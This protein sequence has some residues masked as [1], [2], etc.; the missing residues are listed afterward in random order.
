MPVRPTSLPLCLFLSVA[1]FL[2]AGDARAQAVPVGLGS[3]SLTRPAGEVGPQSASNVPIVPKVAAAFAQPVQTN[4][5]WSSLIYPFF[6]D[7]YSNILYAH[8]VNARA[9]AQGMQIGATN[10]VQFVAND[11]LYPFRSDLTVGA[12]RLAA[13]RAV[14]DRYGD[15]TV[16]ARWDGGP[17]GFRATLGHGLPFV[18]FRITGGDALVTPAQG[19]TVWSNVGGVLG[20]TIAGNHYGVFAPTGATWTGTTPLRSTL[21]G[22]GY[23]SVAL[24]PDARPETLERFRRHAYAFVTDSRVAWAYDEATAQVTS[25]YAYTT[26]AM[27]GGP[28]LSSET[29]TALY[30]HQWLDST[31]PATGLTYRSPRG[32]MRLVEGS[33]FTTRRAFTGVLPALPGGGEVNPADLRALVQQAAQETLPAG[34]SYENGKA[35]SRFAHLVHIADQLGAVCRTRPLSR[36]DQGAPR[37]LVHGRWCAGVLL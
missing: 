21:A 23:L 37:G 4:D 20:L 7:P 18:F 8:P 5:Y 27:E 13:S 30:R 1:I 19:T 15:W 17:V 9:T 28:G 31:T 11:F 32:E 10:A 26:E 16:T 12:S 2:P 25:T 34:P 29:M 6:G 14:T 3:Y 24:L 35:M 33:T 22:R 36:P